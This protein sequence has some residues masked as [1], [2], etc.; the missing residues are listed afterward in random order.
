[1]VD[2]RVAVCKF[3]AWRKKGNFLSEG[4]GGKSRKG[5][6]PSTAFADRTKHKDSGVPSFPV[7]R[8]QK[9]TSYLPAR[10][11]GFENSRN[12]RARLDGV[13]KERKTSKLGGKHIITFSVMTAFSP[14]I[15]DMDNPM[16]ARK[17]K[18]LPPSPCVSPMF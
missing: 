3:L 17:L 7:S 12:H 9:P 2:L 11:N 10:A 8:A 18:C 16:D 5:K 14:S 4:C 1:M 6:V 13:T 15:S